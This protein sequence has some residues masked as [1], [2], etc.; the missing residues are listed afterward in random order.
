MTFDPELDFET[1]TD[2]LAP[3]DAKDRIESITN[4]SV[5]EAERLTE[6]ERFDAYNQQSSGQ[7]TTDPPIAGGPTDDFIHLMETPADQWGDDELKE[8]DE[9][10]NYASRT[11][12]QYDDGEGEPLLPEKKPDIHK[13]EMA[14][15]TWGMDPNP[16][17]DFP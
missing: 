10:E 17:D 1:D 5:D 13:G 9:L 4:M 16:D 2:E 11:V 6:S 7:E 8:A 12:P 14:L 3:A 15:M